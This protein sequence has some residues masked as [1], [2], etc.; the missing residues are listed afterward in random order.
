MA[1]G[2]RSGASKVRTTVPRLFSAPSRC[3]TSV[4]ATNSRGWLHRIQ[5][6]VTTHMLQQPTKQQSRAR[7][8]SHVNVLMPP[9]RE[10][11]T[12]MMRTITTQSTLPM[13]Y[14]IIITKRAA[15]LNGLFKTKRLR[16]Y[17]KRVRKDVAV[18]L[19]NLH[20]PANIQRPSPFAHPGSLRG[21]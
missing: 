12:V 11:S 3:T 2:A 13:T 7:A 1:P 17:A 9:W 19:P 5:Q 4:Q 21:V 18:R 8:Q 20:L 15:R 14:S 16:A 10:N 6:F